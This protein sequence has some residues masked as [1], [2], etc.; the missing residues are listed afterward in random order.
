VKLRRIVSS[1]KRLNVQE[2]CWRCGEKIHTA[3][4]EP[5][6]CVNQVNLRSLEYPLSVRGMATE[7]KERFRELAKRNGRDSTIKEKPKDQSPPT[8][9][10]REQREEESLDQ[11]WYQNLYAEHLKDVMDSTKLDLNH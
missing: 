1:Q 6:T 8:E 5:K 7:T 9:E 10:E 4:N 2:M 11:N 3:R